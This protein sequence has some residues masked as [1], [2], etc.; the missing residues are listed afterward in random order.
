MIARGAMGLDRGERGGTEH[1][2]RP[3]VAH[4]RVRPR[5]DLGT[6]VPAHHRPDN[7]RFQPASIAAARRIFDQRGRQPPKPQQARG[8]P[9]R[10]AGQ[11][12][13]QRIAP[14]QGAVEIEQRDVRPRL[15]CGRGVHADNIYEI[16]KAPWLEQARSRGIRR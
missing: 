16:I 11:K 7:A 13:H 2:V 4:E 14:S 12:R 6:A 8:V 5:V 9:K 10:V 1:M 15:G 3:E